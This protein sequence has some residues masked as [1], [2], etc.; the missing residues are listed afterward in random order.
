MKK[1]DQNS[2]VFVAGARGMVG[3]AFVRKLE[4]NGYRNLLTPSHKELDL[5]N[6]REVQRF[7]QTEKPEFVFVAAA[8]VGGIYYNSTYIADFLYENIM[9]EANILHS[10][11]END[12]EKLLFLGS[13]C[14][15]PKMAPQPMHE[16]SLLT[17]PLEPTNEGYALAKIVGL[18][19]CEYIQRQYNRRFI[20]AMPT[21]L[22]GTNDNFHPDHS[23]VIP[24]L[25]RRFHEVKK[26]GAPTVTVWGTGKPLREFLNVDDLA[27]ALYVLMHDYEDPQTINIGT[28]QELTIKEL[29]YLI[30]EVVGY[31]GDIVFDTSKPD[32][33][34][35]KLLDV[36]R[37]NKLGWKAKIP[38]KEGLQKAYQ[39]AIDN[40]KL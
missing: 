3:S 22:Y 30:K 7:F 8:K 16:D 35:R 5:T 4:T 36:S 2:K 26:A 20:S 11:L 39:W 27:D 29:A 6:Q 32:G 12:T 33:T 31:R 15:Y 14:I 18:K 19:Y 34:P 1:F 9:I 17:G 38:L 23:H 13:S 28:G 25:V 40:G 21:N 37:I 10:A 24:G